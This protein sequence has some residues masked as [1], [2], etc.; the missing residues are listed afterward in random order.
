MRSAGSLPSAKNR[1]RSPA[2][3]LERIKQA[4]NEGVSNSAFFRNQYRI[5]P[6]PQ[7]SMPL[8]SVAIDG[9]VARIGSAS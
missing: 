8:L 1:R 4:R 3:H 5:A 7:P 6:V 9:T 2:S